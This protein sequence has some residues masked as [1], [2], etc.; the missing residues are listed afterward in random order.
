[1]WIVGTF[2]LGNVDIAY[3]YSMDYFGYI[4][5][6]QPLI[7]LQPEENSS[8]SLIKKRKKLNEWAF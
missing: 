3:T 4:V 2:K 8:Q 1:M 7:Y 6:R 5:L